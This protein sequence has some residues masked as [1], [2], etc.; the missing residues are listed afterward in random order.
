MFQCLNSRKA[1]G[2]DRLSPCLLK[3]CANQL[4]SVFIDIFNV[5]LSQCKI[6]HCFKKSTI[7][8]VPNKSTASCLNDYRPVYC[9]MINFLWS[10][11]SKRV[12]R[13]DL[14]ATDLVHVLVSRVFPQ[15]PRRDYLVVDDRQMVSLIYESQRVPRVGAYT[16]KRDHLTRTTTHEDLCWDYH[17]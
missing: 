6:P 2:P 16:S 4:S 17:T 5:S 13:F 1:A 3:L 14:P 12:R 8:P 15:M 11:M 9:S 7:I 10:F